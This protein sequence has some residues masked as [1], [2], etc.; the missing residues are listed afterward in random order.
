MHVELGSPADPAA[1]ALLEASHALMQSLFPAESNHYLSIDALLADEITFWVAKEGPATL[2]C[3]A[4][5]NKGT[6]GEVKS[7]F[8]DPKARGKGVGQA[9]LAALETHAKAQGLPLLRLETGDLLHAAHRLYRRHG[10]VDCDA[11]GDYPPDGA[12][13]VYMEKEIT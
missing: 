1:T 3:V 7:M 13:S 6:Y 4:L 2:G 12:H 11:F 10:F 8:V 5:A 9:L